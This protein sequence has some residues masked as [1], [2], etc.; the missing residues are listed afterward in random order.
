MQPLLDD[1]L[2][3]IYQEIKADELAAAS[4]RITEQEGNQ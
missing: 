3:S 4:R 2:E 1:D